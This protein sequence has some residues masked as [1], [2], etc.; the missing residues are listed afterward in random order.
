MGRAL[1]ALFVVRMRRLIED[2]AG[3]GAGGEAGPGLTQ[4]FRRLHWDSPPPPPP[5]LHS[6]QA[7][8]LGS[9]LG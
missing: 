1:L 2:G 5:S 7:T 4:V 8:A 9:Y 6:C 3:R